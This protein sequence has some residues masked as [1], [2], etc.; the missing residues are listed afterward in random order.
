MELFFYYGNIVKVGKVLSKQKITER[1]H[2]KK[3]IGFFHYRERK[4]KNGRNM[5]SQIIYYYVTLYIW[6]IIN[7][8]AS[9]II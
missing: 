4:K 9:W 3:K 5:F 7:V 8:F 2:W 6:G 1:N